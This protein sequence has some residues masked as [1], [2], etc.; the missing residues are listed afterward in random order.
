MAKKT[1]RIKQGESYAYD[2]TI[3]GVPTLDI[4]WGGTWE[5]QATLGGVAEASGS[6]ALSGDST[7]LEMRI[8][9]T[10]T[11]NLDVGNH[12]LVVEVVNTTISFNQEPM[13]DKFVVDA[14]GIS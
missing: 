3:K 9:P 7:A 4:N 13:Q 5:I 12:I 2:F 14:Q 10:D 11:N 1:H 6:L 8:L